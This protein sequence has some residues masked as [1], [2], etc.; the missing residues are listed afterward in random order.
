MSSV[1]EAID[2]CLGRRYDIDVVVN[3]LGREPAVIV[4]EL[5]HVCSNI[6]KAN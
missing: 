1:R 3:F 5:E 2:V 4:V 6:F